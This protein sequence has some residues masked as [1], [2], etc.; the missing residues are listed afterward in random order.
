M[1]CRDI[2]DV[3]AILILDAVSVVATPRPEQCD[4]IDDSS[5]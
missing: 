5:R 1:K 3:V 4:P 2:F